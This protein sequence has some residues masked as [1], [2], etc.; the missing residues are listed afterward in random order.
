MIRSI[1]SIV[2]GYVAWML[3]VWI[4]WTVFGYG[5]RDVPPTDFLI[6]SVFFVL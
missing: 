2:A 4:I 6:F 1:I 3:A 5:I